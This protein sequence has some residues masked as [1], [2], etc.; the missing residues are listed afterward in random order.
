MKQIL[1][2]TIA[3]LNGASM[4]MAQNTVSVTQ[5]FIITGGIASTRNR[6]GRKRR[7]YQSRTRY[8]A[9]ANRA[10]PGATRYTVGPDRLDSA[11]AGRRR[12]L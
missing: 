9:R 1:A 8:F 2:I 12:T 3:M 10:Q 11:G 4:A 7:G 5:P 6:N